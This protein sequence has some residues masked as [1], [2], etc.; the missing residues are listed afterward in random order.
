M[1][2][3]GILLLSLAC[4]CTSAQAPPA[5][6][7]PPPA[8]RPDP[9]PP[10]APDPRPELKIGGHAVKVR[11]ALT[12]DQRF[13]GLKGVKALADDEGMLFAYKEKLIRGFW[14]KGCVIPLDIVF[15][16]DDGR[17]LSVSTM[18]P[19]KA[20]VSDDDLP[21]AKPPEA[22]RL[23]LELPGGWFQ[24]HGLG[25]GSGTKVEGLAGLPLAK[26]E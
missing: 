18:E 7:A 12:S 17:V 20:G 10:P 16:S 5:P 9:A 6:P 15:L 24:R 11:L 13:D 25:A 1:R 4:A 8:P 19:P 14:M 3:I 22:C 23:V 26:A 2:T 21:R